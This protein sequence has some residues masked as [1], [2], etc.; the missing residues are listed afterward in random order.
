MCYVCSISNTHH[1]SH[2]WSVAFLNYVTFHIKNKARVPHYFWVPY[3]PLRLVFSTLGQRMTKNVCSK[4]LELDLFCGFSRDF[5]KNLTQFFQVNKYCVFTLKM[6]KGLQK[7]RIARPSDCDPS[8]FCLNWFFFKSERPGMF[9][10]WLWAFLFVLF[11]FFLK[12]SHKV[13]FLKV[14]SILLSK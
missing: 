4:T 7:W 11:S 3:W 2:C 13:M 12:W 9:L 1:V 5:Q 8:P 10:P 6:I 14:K